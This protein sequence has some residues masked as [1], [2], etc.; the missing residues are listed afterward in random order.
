ML[1]E[2]LTGARPVRDRGPHPGGSRARRV[3]LRAREPEH[4]RGRVARDRR[5]NRAADREGSNG[6][7][8]GLRGDLDVICLK[9]LQKDPRAATRRSRRC[10]TTSRATSGLP[11]IARP[12]TSVYRIGKFV[13]RHRLGWASP[14]RWRRVRG[15]VTYL[16]GA[17]VERARS[18]QQEATKAEQVASFSAAV[19]GL[20]SVG[21]E[22]PHGHRARA[23]RSRRRA[24]R[25]TSW[26]DS[27]R[28][29]P[30]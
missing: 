21:V 16:H 13:S 5:A 6:S 26:R 7:S 8:G 22:R 27:P 25:A 11:V 29:A 28:S 18:R 24:H 19:R 30:R 12:D 2:L 20:G 4:P 10:R 1:Y 15:V 3:R 14:Q 23:A 9:A 17:P